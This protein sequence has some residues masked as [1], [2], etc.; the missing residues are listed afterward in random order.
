MPFRQIDPPNQRRII[1]EKAIAFESKKSMANKVKRMEQIKRFIRLYLVR[2][3]Y[4]S[5]S[6]QTGMSRNTIKL[7]L[8]QCESSSYSLREI[9][10]LPESELRKIL[11]PEYKESELTC[12]ADFEKHLEYWL[13]ELRRPGVTRFLLWQEYMH[14]YP[15]RLEEDLSSNIPHLS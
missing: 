1:N 13:E 9:L 7:Y 12:E 5:V 3:S 11:Y 10:E 4:K 6:R 14:R 15:I 2:G 8:R